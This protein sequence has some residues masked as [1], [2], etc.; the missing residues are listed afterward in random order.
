[1]RNN[2]NK[3]ILDNLNTLDTITVDYNALSDYYI[4]DVNLKIDSVLHTNDSDLEFYLIHNGITDT[5][6]YQAG[7]TGQNF[8]GTILNDSASTP[9]SSETAPFTGSFKPH[10]P[11]SQFNGQGINGA[12]ILKI[13]D[14]ATGNTGTLNSWSIDFL[15]S[16]NP[17]GIQNISNEIPKSYFLSQ[18]YPNPF[19]PTTNIKFSI[20]KASLVKL[21]VYDI[22]GRE[23]ETLVNE[24]LNAGTYNADWNASNYSSGVYFYKVESADFND[25]KKM[26][27]VK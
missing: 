10:K 5:A 14:R 17:I 27:L 22:T 9:I 13:Y 7:G 15:L 24:I 19:N 6:I 18:N 11:L 1:I 26:V 21:V 16:N 12:W 23:V 3:P 25:V 8:I 4:Y 20:P 2:L